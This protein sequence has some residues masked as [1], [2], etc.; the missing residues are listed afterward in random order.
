M[1]NLK[2]NNYLLTLKTLYMEHHRLKPMKP[3]YDEKL[4]NELYKKTTPL[5]KKLAF[6]IDA[7]KFGVDYQEILSWFD[8]KFI[9]T[10]NKYCDTKPDLLLGY[11]IS[12]LQTYK[13]RVMRSSY[14]LKHANHANNLDITELYNYDSIIEESDNSSYKE[15]YL[16][17]ALEFMKGKLDD[18]A[19]LIVEIELS[20]PPFIIDGMADL[21]KK[22]G[23]KIPNEL[24]AD[25]LGFGKST[26][27]IEYVKELRS[28]IK[29][30]TGLAKKY[31]LENP[32]TPLTA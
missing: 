24:I 16:N 22:E 5:R 13:Y 6:Q 17:K 32:I 7:R 4:F 28:D 30:V 26:N 29:Y 10:F 12:S 18:N 31:F 23:Q 25:Y 15:L 20:P 1:S 11:I 27:F 8:V 2:I 14:Q 3:D 9:Y 21:D 19:M